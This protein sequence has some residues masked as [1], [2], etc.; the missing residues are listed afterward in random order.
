M[1][2]GCVVYLNNDNKWGPFAYVMTFIRGVQDCVLN[3]WPNCILGF[4]FESKI[5]PF[6]VNKFLQSLLIFG[7]NL[8]VIP[9]MVDDPV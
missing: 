1:G 3:C 7:F 6:G 4:E 5:A 9:V 8:I 2:I